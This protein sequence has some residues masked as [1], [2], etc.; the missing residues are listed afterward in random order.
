MASPRIGS[1][2]QAQRGVWAGGNGDGDFASAEHYYT[3]AIAENPEDPVSALG[4]ALSVLR[5]GQHWGSR[6]KAL[7][8]VVSQHGNN[9]TLKCFY[10]MAMAM[11]GDS[12]NAIVQFQRARALGVD[13]AHVFPR[14]LV[15]A[16]ERSPGRNQSMGLARPGAPCL[17]RADL[18]STKGLTGL[19]LR[20]LGGHWPVSW[21]SI[22]S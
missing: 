13:P 3:Q 2:T 17:R 11:D 19:S 5:N 21:R 7:E 18:E 12:K 16:I 20:S 6:A 8:A 10:G 22:R 1:E 4:L 9:G 15:E 14:K